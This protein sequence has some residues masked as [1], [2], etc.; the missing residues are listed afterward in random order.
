[1]LQFCHKDNDYRIL[2]TKV[3]ILKMCIDQECDRFLTQVLSI[4]NRIDNEF[5]FNKK[6]TPCNI[7]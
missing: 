4:Y 5:V 1:M 2:C 6:K 3:Y 7:F